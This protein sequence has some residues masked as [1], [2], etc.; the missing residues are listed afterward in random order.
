MLSSGCQLTKALPTADLA[1]SLLSVVL[2]PGSGAGVGWGV[3]VPVAGAGHSADPAP[4]PAWV[5]S[6]VL[7]MTGSHFCWLTGQGERRKLGAPSLLRR[8]LPCAG[9]QVR[10]TLLQRG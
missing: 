3:G 6:V 1:G 7:E 10:Y 4:P 8:P 9:A 2:A 5:L